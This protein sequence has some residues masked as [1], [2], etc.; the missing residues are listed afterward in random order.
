M[1]KQPTETDIG[2]RLVG[3]CTGDYR[4]R[5]ST[6]TLDIVVTADAEPTAL[7]DGAAELGLNIGS[8]TMVFWPESL[9]PDARLQQCAAHLSTYEGSVYAADEDDLLVN[10]VVPLASVAYG[11][12]PYFPVTG[13]TV[14]RMTE[15][16]DY[17]DFLVDAD[18]AVARGLFPDHLTHPLVRLGD[19]C[20]LAGQLPCHSAQ[21]RRVL[22]AAAGLFH[23]P[24]GEPITTLPSVGCP[25]VR[26]IHSSAQLSAERAARPWLARFT[27]VL[28]VLAALRA[29][30]HAP[31]NTTT[32]SGFGTRLTA[33]APATPTEAAGRPVIVSRD[34][35]A[36]ICDPN[37]LRVMRVSGDVARVG[38]LMLAGDSIDRSEL[39]D[40]VAE[41]LAVESRPAADALSTVYDTLLGMGC[42]LPEL[43]PA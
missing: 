11:S 4:G 18:R 3:W 38:E 5:A 31:A 28:G 21:Q 1:R 6:G 35:E 24:Y 12:G 25:C 16:A 17:L 23:S 41:E 19:T 37:S 32:V 13:P 43:S 40:Q 30:A 10:G 22:V 20:A 9:R 42:A 33:A 29:R 7:L 15:P 26:A 34:Q 2:S 8:E 14:L 36:L 39:T 27:E